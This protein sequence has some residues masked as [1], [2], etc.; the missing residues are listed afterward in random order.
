MIFWTNQVIGVVGLHPNHLGDWI[1]QKIQPIHKNCRYFFQY[2]D[3]YNFPQHA[4]DKALEEE[5]VES[6]EEKEEEKEEGAAKEEE[7][8]ELAEESEEEEEEV[9]SALDVVINTWIH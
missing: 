5:E 6:E 7:E 2:G 1:S 8:E 3:I 4:F 9:D